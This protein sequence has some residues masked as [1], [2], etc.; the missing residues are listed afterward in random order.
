VAVVRGQLGC[1]FPTR[2]IRTEFVLS[3]L[4]AA[5]SFAEPPQRPSQVF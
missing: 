2:G 5:A 4:S 3:D 1:L